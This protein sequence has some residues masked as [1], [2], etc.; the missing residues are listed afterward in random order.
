MVPERETRASCVEPSS[1]TW[2]KSWEPTSPY[3][4]NWCPTKRHSSQKVEG[5]TELDLVQDEV[6]EAKRSLEEAHL[7][8]QAA[9]NLVIEAAFRVGQAMEEMAQIR[10]LLGVN[11]E[12][13][14][15]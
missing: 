10:K 11:P 2:A 3:S 1:T 7:D 15:Q 4:G 5:R 6:D 13:N 12:P 8:A 9:Q 14:D